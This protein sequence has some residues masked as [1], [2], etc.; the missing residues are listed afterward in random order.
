MNKSEIPKSETNGKKMVK[1]QQPE[2]MISELLSAISETEYPGYILEAV[3]IV[4]EWMNDAIERS[5]SEEITQRDIFSEIFGAEFEYD[6]GGLDDLYARLASIEEF[7][8]IIPNSKKADGK[9]DTIIISLATP[10]Y[11]GG[12]RAAIDHAAIFNRGNC[13]RVWIISDTFMLGEIIR[14]IPHVDALAEQ[15]IILR[16]LLV[17]PWGWVE[18]PLSGTSASKNQFL[19]RTEKLNK[20]RRKQ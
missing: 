20:R 15:E 8:D 14:F 2:M 7:A 13:H 10:D 6:T 5:K 4:R 9:S 11:E 12:L 17:T 16:F 19:W 3:D 18:L 1:K